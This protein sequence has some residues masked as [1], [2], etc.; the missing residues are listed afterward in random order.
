MLRDKG[1]CL[2]VLRFE[3][4]NANG[5]QSNTIIAADFF[6]YTNRQHQSNIIYNSGIYLKKTYIL[7]SAPLFTFS[8]SKNAKSKTWLRAVARLQT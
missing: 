1:H 2:Q 4:G 6:N 8:N 5:K 3:R 7:H